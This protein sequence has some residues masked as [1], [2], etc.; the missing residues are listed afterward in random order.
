MGIGDS[1]RRE[2]GRD[3][4]GKRRPGRRGLSRRDLFKIGDRVEGKEH[5]P[6]NPLICDKQ[7]ST[8]KGGPD[9]WTVEARDKK[10]VK[11]LE[12]RSRGLYRRRWRG[13][14]VREC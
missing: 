3:S 2:K 11:V 4:E 9:E 1:L 5:K 8:K 13:G 14:G 10:E 12:T 7:D 6:R